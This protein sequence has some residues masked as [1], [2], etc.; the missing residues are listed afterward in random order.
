MS[1]YIC[2]FVEMIVIVKFCDEQQSS[3]SKILINMKAYV[4]DAS[5]T[6]IASVRYVHTYDMF[7]SANLLHLVQ[8]VKLVDSLS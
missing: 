6:E 4:S 5:I 8:K 3:P 7:S 2:S 1:S